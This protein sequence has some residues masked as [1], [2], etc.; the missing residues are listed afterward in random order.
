[1]LK[2]ELYKICRQKKLYLVLCICFAVFACYFFVL[3]TVSPAYGGRIPIYQSV[4]DDVYSELEKLEANQMLTNEERSAMKQDFRLQYETVLKLVMAAGDRDWPEELKL[5]N[6]LDEAQ[7]SGRY[8]VYYDQLI[9]QVLQDETPYTRIAYRNYLIEHKIEPDFSSQGTTAVRFMLLIN[10]IMMPFFLPLLAIFIAVLCVQ[11]EFSAKTLKFCLQLPYSRAM[12]ISVKLAAGFLVSIAFVLL[13]LVFCFFTPLCLNGLGYV[14][15]PIKVTAGLPNLLQLG[16]ST[17]ATAQTL[18]L[19]VLALIP[20]NIVFYLV[21]SSLLF[22]LLSGS[23]TSILL[24]V[25]LLISANALSHIVTARIFAFL[26]FTITDTYSI[27]TKQQMGMPYISIGLLFVWL[28][29]S[30]TVL[31]FLFR[32]KELYS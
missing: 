26:P 15:Y 11:E 28:A 7:L 3:N 2:T 25:F 16:D 5:L 6:A 19:L 31:L 8:Y 24:A 32:R 27:F 23:S 30:F 4:K 10:E 18:I 13:L 29:G 17:Y 21:F 9:E 1:M 20:V 14:N 12:L 22:L